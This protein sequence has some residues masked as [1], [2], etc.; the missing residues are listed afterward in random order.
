[1]TK[2]WSDVLAAWLSSRWRM[3]SLAGAPNF[4]FTYRVA[5]HQQ[6]LQP[7]VNTTTG[8][9]LIVFLLVGVMTIIVEKPRP[10]ESKPGA[11]L[12][13]LAIA[14]SWAI[15]LTGRPP[16]WI[17]PCVLEFMAGQFLMLLAVKER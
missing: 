7:N 16:E 10:N 13:V 3:A 12:A 5:V 17:M 6:G 14:A 8:G 4:C 15:A 2:S 11:L 9:G 1:M